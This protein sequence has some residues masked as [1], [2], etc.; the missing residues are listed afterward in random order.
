VFL[1]KGA[2]AMQRNRNLFAA[3]VIFMSAALLM[4]LF[5]QP[6]KARSQETQQLQKSR[7]VHEVQIIKIRDVG[8]QGALRIEPSEITIP[9]GM[10]VVWVNMSRK[11][12]PQII[13]A[14]GMK[15]ELSTEAS[16]G[17][18]QDAQKCYITDF[19]EV[20][21]TSSLKFIGEGTFNYEVRNRKGQ[22]GKGTIKV[23]SD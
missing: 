18:K 2:I 9:V 16:V 7:E 17:F 19:V 10:V 15:C 12:E 4:G 8:Y 21:G 23:T 20:G 1:T 14:E 22:T 11:S 5:A 6:E 13:F 3:A